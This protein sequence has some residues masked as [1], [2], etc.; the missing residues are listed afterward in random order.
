MSIFKKIKHGVKKAAHTVEHTAE[1]AEKTTVHA[2]SIA[3]NEVSKTANTATDA[4][5]TVANQAEDIVANLNPE[6]LA[7]E[8]KHEVLKAINEVKAEAL[9]A[10]K[11]A[12]KSAESEIKDLAEQGLSE[13]KKA[14]LDFEKILVG[15]TA[16]EVLEYAAKVIRAI[17]PKSLLIHLGPLQVDIGDIVSKVEHIEH[18]AAHPPSTRS[19]WKQF[20]LDTAPASIAITAS[21]GFAFILESSD[22]EVEVQATW[23]GDDVI[24]KID[25]ILEH[26]GI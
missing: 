16:Q 22:F 3:G 17:S 20:V 14:V 12:E 23:E 8:V 5:N 7:N 13:I 25:R 26:A 11:T 9:S 24:E 4:V 18:Y 15:K 19:E 1:S 21:V 2:V 6:H 10:I